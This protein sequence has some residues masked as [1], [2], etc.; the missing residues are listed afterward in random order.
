VPDS[1]EAACAVAPVDETDIEGVSVVL[2]ALDEEATIEAVTEAV[3]DACHALGLRFEIIIVDDG[4]R[5][6]TGDRA[7]HLARRDPRV[8]VIRHHRNR[9][10]G[11]ALRS[12]FSAATLPWLFFTDADGQFEPRDLRLLIPLTQ[13]AD[14]VAGYRAR[15][16]DPFHRR[17]YGRLFGR[18][19]RVL[20]GV[21][22]R[23]VNCA[24]KLMRRELVVALGLRSEGAVVNAELLG[25]AARAG[26]RI[27][28]VGVR[29][30]P[31]RAGRPTG[32][33]PRVIVRA[34]RE[35]VALRPEIRRASGGLADG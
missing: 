19:V 11:A 18:M 16:S 12:G 32:G 35:L 33:D 22:S 1:V 5:D 15:R 25:K 23:D 29:H 3:R 13:H 7:A 20:L 8:R 31:R 4:S 26:A 6:G 21:R 2:P 28:E 17:L 34:L 30:R 9:G 10:Y 14:I 27:A 24:F